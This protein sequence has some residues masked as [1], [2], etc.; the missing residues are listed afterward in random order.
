MKS[1]RQAILIALFITTA[2]VATTAVSGT[3]AAQ[4]EIDIQWEQNS[5]GANGGT[6]PTTEDIKIES[7]DDP[8]SFGADTGRSLRIQDVDTGDSITLTPT[9][10]TYDVT[11][12][13]VNLNDFVE[14]V[15]DGEY[16]KSTNP[17]IQVETD[18]G[19]TLFEYP[20]EIDG[21]STALYENT[22]SEYNIQLIGST[23]SVIAET[24]ESKIKASGYEE[25]YQ[26]NGS[27]VGVEAPSGLQPDWY[28]KLEQSDAEAETVYEYTGRYSTGDEYIVFELDSDFDSNTDFGVEIYPDE[29]QTELGDRIASLFGAKLADADETDR[30]S[31]VDGPVGSAS[32]PDEDDSSDNSSDAGPTTDPATISSAT[33]VGGQQSNVVYQAKGGT[34]YQGQDVIATGENIN[35]NDN[36]YA[37]RQIGSFDSGTVDGS[38]Q[39]EALQTYVV[40]EDND[41]LPAYVDPAELQDGEAFLVLETDDKDA[42]DY[43]VRGSSTTV[44]PDE[45]DGTFELVV[46]DLNIQFEADDVPVTN[47]GGDAVAELKID[48]NRVNYNTNISTFDEFNDEELLGILI[49]T[50]LNGVGDT[51]IIS[52]V[53]YTEAAIESAILS[54]DAREHVV[55]NADGELAV[56][57]AGTVTI[58]DVDGNTNT[59]TVGEL[60]DTDANPFNAL[61]Y[62]LDESDEVGSDDDAESDEKLVLS[63]I[64]NPEFDIS[65]TDIDS[66]QYDIVAHVDDTTASAQT[67]TQVEGGASKPPETSVTV[68]LNGAPTGLQTYNISVAGPDNTSITAVEPDAVS[69]NGFQIV[70]GGEGDSLVTARGADLANT[71]GS[72]SDQ[73]V[74][75]EVTFQGTVSSGDVSLTVHDLEDNNGDSIDTSSVTLDVQQ[76]GGTPFSGG[77][78]GVGAENAPKDIDGDGKFED[79]NGDG[80]TDFTDAVDLAFA[81]TT[82]LSEEQAAALDFDGDGDVDFSDAVELAFTT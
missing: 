19:E 29:T 40:G 36:D 77:V 60:R 74:L 71:I 42:D 32:A 53:E 39:V 21:D 50:N 46:Q 28:I 68:Q 5:A 22:F 9:G 15:G 17:V 33:Q 56:E 67:S 72:T 63:D 1:A 43:F 11:V 37:L 62:D 47:E 16:E 65:F 27:V 35:A 34:A 80:E 48:S 18:Q 79:V 2:G 66:G 23:G 61:A 82:Q 45:G 55:T 75:Y 44:N 3:T 59:V 51:V 52:G 57:E 73:L 38:S 10:S 25:T 30:V 26:Y 13:E 12:F 8:I 31:V 14:Q 6:I 69:G 24:D 78:P 76:P 70:D 49:N 58:D 81:D 7:V 41:E 4:A 64:S 20:V 54:Q